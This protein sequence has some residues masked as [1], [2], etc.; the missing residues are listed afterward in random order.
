MEI[1]KVSI[2]GL[3]ENP[4]DF[5]AAGKTG[6]IGRTMNILYQICRKRSFPPRLLRGLFT[7]DT[8]SDKIVMLQSPACG[9]SR[10]YAIIGVN[11]G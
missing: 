2:K 7:I 5:R 10:F 4:Q 1:F 11:S 9:F 3:F 6:Q 8:G